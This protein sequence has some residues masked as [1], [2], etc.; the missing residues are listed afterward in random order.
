MKKT[1]EVSKIVGVSKRTLQYYDD[2]GLLL[3]DRTSNNHRLYDQKT[4]ERIWEILVYKEMGFEL[5]EIKSYLE[6]PDNRQ[7]K[8]FK[9]RIEEIQNEITKLKVQM[10][11]ILSVQN[12]GIPPIPTDTSENTYIESILELRERMRIESIRE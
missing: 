4:L 5:K 3:L 11:W 7:K 2:E 10:R 8:Y 1:N 12:E 6:F 9:Q